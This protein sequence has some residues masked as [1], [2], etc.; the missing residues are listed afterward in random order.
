MRTTKVEGACFGSKRSPV[1]VW[2]PRPAG[3]VE[4]RSELAWCTCF[5]VAW[6]RPG[7]RRGSRWQGQVLLRATIL[8]ASALPPRTGVPSVPWSSPQARGSGQGRS[9]DAAV[10]G[11]TAEGLVS[12]RHRTPE[13]AIPAGRPINGACCCARSGRRRLRGDNQSTRKLP[14]WLTM[15]GSRW[16]KKSEAAVERAAS[17]PTPVAVRLA[18]RS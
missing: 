8:E 4:V 3:Q 5:G 14:S 6:A 12:P 10:G 13:F 18:V 2:A 16:S 1:R 15:P 9:R 11:D 7:P 17:L